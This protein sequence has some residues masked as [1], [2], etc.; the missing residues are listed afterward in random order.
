MD[1]M[2]LQSP[3][4]ISLGTVTLL[5]GAVLFVLDRRRANRQ[6]RLRRAMNSFIRANAR[7]TFSVITYSN[8]SADT[9]VPLL[10]SLQ[11]QGYAQLPVIV[12]TSASATKQE[13]NALR[14]L[15]RQKR[16][17]LRLRVVRQTSGD[18]RAL[19]RR[20]ADGEALV[21]LNPADR[22]SSDFFTR[23]SLELLDESRQAIAPRVALSVDDTLW[24]ANRA[25]HIVARQTLAAIAGRNVPGPLVVRRDAYVKDSVSRPISVEHS[26][27]T[28]SGATAGRFNVFI[29]FTLLIATLLVAVTSAIFL[30]YGWQLVTA[31]FVGL[32]ALLM[33]VR[34]LSYPYSTWTK[35]A[36][37]LLIPL[38]PIV[39]VIFAGGTATR[40]LL[41]RLW[42]LRVR[43]AGAP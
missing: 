2:F 30:V 9:L 21:W 11:S 13:L 38:W 16:G 23:M 17:S 22:L 36:L 39:A 10:D 34:L 33:V 1:L 3:L 5:F 37:T 25:L 41:S 35:I 40:R 7:K 18:E 20:Y 29:E 4:L 12:L 15:Q 32:I 26:A 8:G 42:K 6:A 31:A 27:L 24:S 28:I 19:I 14:R 43:P